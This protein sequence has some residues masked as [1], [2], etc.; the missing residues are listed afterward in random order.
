MFRTRTLTT[1]K[2]KPEGVSKGND[3]NENRPVLPKIQSFKEHLIH[4][5]KKEN[6]NGPC[7]HCLIFIGKQ[8]TCKVTSLCHLLSM[9]TRTPPAI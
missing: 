2:R 3:A 5:I 6:D 9:S 8:N 1:L 7:V 4:L